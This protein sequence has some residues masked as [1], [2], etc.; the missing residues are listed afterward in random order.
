MQL[1]TEQLERARA[2]RSEGKSYLKIVAETG[3]SYFNLRHALEP[4]F[5]QKHALRMEEQRRRMRAR[6]RKSERKIEFKGQPDIG[7]VGRLAA[8]I[9]NEYDRRI[10]DAVL[11]ERNRVAS[12]E[13]TINMVV[14]GD[15]APGRS[16]WDRRR[17]ND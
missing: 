11:A 13:R 3:V 10:P 7:P 1:Q 2:L 5:R 15:P 4:E 17:A 6:P 9:H 16:A 12:A 14:L 8:G